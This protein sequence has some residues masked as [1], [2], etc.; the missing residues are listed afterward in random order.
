MDLHSISIRK[1]TEI[2]D[3]QF[4]HHT[5]I[6]HRIEYLFERRAYASAY[7]SMTDSVTPLNSA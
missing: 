3:R 2:K 5:L 1:N 6:K 4:N 7:S